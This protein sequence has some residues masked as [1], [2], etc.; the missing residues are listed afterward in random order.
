MKIA[1]S[2]N[3]IILSFYFFSIVLIILI[4]V[5]F[6]NGFNCHDPFSLASSEGIRR[7]AGSHLREGEQGVLR[8]LRGKLRRQ[9][10]H[11]KNPDLTSYQQPGNDFI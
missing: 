1:L 4:L 3:L 10:R 11:R 9:T 6:I 2:N 7:F 5:L 8:R